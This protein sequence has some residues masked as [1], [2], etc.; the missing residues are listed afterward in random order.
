MCVRACVCSCV[1][2]CVRVC[3][4]VRACVCVCVRVFVFMCVCACVCCVGVCV[5]MCA[6]VPSCDPDGPH[7]APGSVAQPARTGPW[8]C[9]CERE[10]GVVEHEGFLALDSLKS[11]KTMHDDVVE[12]HM[13]KRDAGDMTVLVFTATHYRILTFRG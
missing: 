10:E 8:E 12:N 4:C 7:L 6:S 2:A 1:R 5:C 13:K 11:S 3:V 9:A